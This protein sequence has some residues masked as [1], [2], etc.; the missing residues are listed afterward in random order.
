MNLDGSKQD[1]IKVDAGGYRNPTSIETI[2]EKE[3]DAYGNIRT[4][5]HGYMNGADVFNFVLREV[6]EDIKQI[7]N[8]S[9]YDVKK[10]I[11]F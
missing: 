1:L 4:D 2:K 3:V 5:E 7:L 9:Q 11:I 6:P 8:F 10:S